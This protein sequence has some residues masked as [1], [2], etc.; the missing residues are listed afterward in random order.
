MAQRQ[1]STRD[2]LEDVILGVETYKGSGYIFTVVLYNCKLS[3]FALHWAIPLHNVD[4]S[5]NVRSWQ[6][7]IPMLW[8]DEIGDL[9]NCKELYM[10]ANITNNVTKHSH[11]MLVTLQGCAWVPLQQEIYHSSLSNR[12]N[13]LS[14]ET[15]DWKTRSTTYQPSSK[16]RET[17]PCLWTPSQTRPAWAELYWSVASLATI[18]HVGLFFRVLTN[19][20]TPSP[21]P[22][23]CKEE[24]CANAM[25]NYM[26]KL[27]SFFTCRSKSPAVPSVNFLCH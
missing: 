20:L 13:T 5:D 19:F 3:Y 14:S 10:T 7:I 21:K 17:R 16:H 23:T 24:G 15:F 25:S 8:R 27:L 11:K 1:F 6:V 22:A 4:H 26:I 9:Q 2:R 18:P 12:Y